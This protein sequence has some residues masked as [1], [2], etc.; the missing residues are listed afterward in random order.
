MAA[1]T[2]GVA[3]CGEGK[4]AL[5]GWTSGAACAADPTSAAPA[6]TR[7]GCGV[8]IRDISLGAGTE[9]RCCCE[10]RG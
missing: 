2:T 5:A 7:S 6:A 4:W 1:F 8:H 3:A 9:V 10:I